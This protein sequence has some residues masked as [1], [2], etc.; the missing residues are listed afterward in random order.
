MARLASGCCAATH[1]R[2]TSE[3]DKQLSA[4]TGTVPGQAFPCRSCPQAWA[5]AS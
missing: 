3:I 1:L 4:E 5:H 2:A